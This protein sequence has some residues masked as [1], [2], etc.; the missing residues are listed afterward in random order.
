MAPAYSLGRL[1]RSYVQPL[2]YCEYAIMHNLGWVHIV[3][4]ELDSWVRQV[5]YTQAHRW[6]GPF[7]T[8][9]CGRWSH[10]C[11]LT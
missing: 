2:E 1:V 11:G 5:I 10:G 3:K 6:D 8:R 7:W 4:E 9:T